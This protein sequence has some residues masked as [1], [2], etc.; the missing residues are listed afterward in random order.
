MIEHVFVSGYSVVDDS[1]Q[2]MRDCVTALAGQD[3]SGW[4]P[5]ALSEL[6][7]ELAAVAERVEAAL[8]R[9]VGEWDA[10]GAWE[11][12]GAASPASW[13]A[14]RVPRTRREAVGL[15]RDGRWVRR[16]ERT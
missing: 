6:V 2:G 11:L 7:V 16:H 3:R 4:A 8:V 1:V 13:L 15:V 9:V 12:E 10:A 5:S 14:A